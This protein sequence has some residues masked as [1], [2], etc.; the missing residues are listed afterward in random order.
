MIFVPNL[1]LGRGRWGG[2]AEE[3]EGIEPL[4]CSV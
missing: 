4:G 2:K 1:A 3:E